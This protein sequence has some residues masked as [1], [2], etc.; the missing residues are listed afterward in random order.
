MAFL[1][2]SFAWNFLLF[3]SLFCIIIYV[4]FRLKYNYWKNKKVKGPQPVF[5]FGNLKN[6]VM[7]KLHM[8][9]HFKNLYS[10]NK[11]LPFIGLHLFVRP[12]LL[13]NN[14]DLMKTILVKDFI[15][16]TDHGLYFDKKTQPLAHHLFNLTGAKW[17]GIRNKLTPA[18][19]SSK[20]KY[21]FETM[22][23][24]GEELSKYL[25]TY[26]VTGDEVDIKDAVAKFSTDV[27]ASCAFGIENFFTKAV[28]KTVKYREE[29]NITRND[30]LQ[31]LIRLKNN[32]NID[33]II[34]TAEAKENETLEFQLTMLEMTAQAFGFFAAGFETSSTS[35]SFIFYQ[36][37][38]HVDVQFKMRQEIDEV[39]MKH[40]GKL[41]YETLTDMT[42]MGQ[43]IDETLRLNPPIPLLFRACT[44]EYV[45]PHTNVVIDKGTMVIFPVMGIHHDPEIYPDPEKFDPE[46]FSPKNKVSRHNYSFI[47]FGEGPRM[48]IGN[49]FAQMQIRLALFSILRRYEVNI[50]VKKEN[51]LKVANN[52]FLVTPKDMNLK[53]TKR[54]I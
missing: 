9:T 33:D 53:L 51:T 34:D 32:E 15:H 25:E 1:F 10:E 2:E 8:G 19:T 36:L 43:V 7:K 27:I 48:C 35:L 5:P 14:L 38:N 12:V 29:N 20:M 52:S 50:G 41:T 49:R 40:A 11:H 22:A 31:L 42:Y 23:V 3:T 37:A 13:V 30:L 26:A 21:M 18:F 45:I 39:L 47:P 28:E 4:W 24:C 44:K 54:T 6:M 17:K 16:F 46:R